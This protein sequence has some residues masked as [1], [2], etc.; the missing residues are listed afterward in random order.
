MTERNS[1]RLRTGLFVSRKVRRRKLKLLC[2]VRLVRRSRISEAKPIIKRIIFNTKNIKIHIF[3]D[4]SQDSLLWLVCL[5]GSQIVR[6]SFQC[7]NPVLLTLYVSEVKRASQKP[8]EQITV[9]KG[10]KLGGIKRS[11]RSNKMN[12]H[13][14]IITLSETNNR[15]LLSQTLQEI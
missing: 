11:Q 5:A 2:Q 7:L 6:T 4:G 3:C 12:N 10:M 13:D 8:K 15:G 9:Q 14:A 1:T